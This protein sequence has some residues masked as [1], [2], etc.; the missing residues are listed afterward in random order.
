MNEAFAVLA[1]GGTVV[2]ANNRLAR[3]LALAWN[4]RE[5][6]AGRSAWHTPAV[7]S[8]Q[9]F[10]ES[11]YA[12]SLV[13]GGRAGGRTLLSGHQS[14]L[15]W[16]GLVAG[17]AGDFLPGAA[18]PVAEL[19]GQAWRLAQDWRI[20][21]AELQATADSE[22][23]RAFAGWAAAYQR[24][25]EV[26]GW[27]DAAAVCALLQVDLQAGSIDAPRRLHLAGFV[28]RTRLQDDLLRSLAVSGCVISEDSAQP[29]GALDACR[30][31]C[32][33]AQAEIAEAARW[34]RQLRA[35][36]AEAAIGIVVPE[37]SGRIA[38][39]RR[40]VLDVLAPDWRL[41]PDRPLPVNFSYGQPLARNGL[42]R[43]ALAVLEA[44]AGRID[45][46]LAAQLLASRYLPGYQPEA[47]GRARVDLAQRGRAGGSLSIAE[48]AEDCAAAAPQ[49]SERL[50]ALA[51][52]IARLPQRQPASSWAAAFRR[53]LEAVGWPGDQALASDEY[54]AATAWQELLGQMRGCDAILGPLD[55]TAAVAV[56]AGL[57][58]AQ[59]FQPA[60]D[61]AVIQVLGVMEAVG[62]RFDALWVCGMTSEAW[63]PAVRSN[64]L[65]SL[66]LQRERRLPD[67]TPALARERAERLLRWLETSADTVVFS[68]PEFEGD[69]PLAPSPLLAGL[70][71][72]PAGL[73]A[74]R[75][76][77]WIERMLGSTQLERLHPDPPPPVAP[78]RCVKGGV[79]LLEQEARCPA[80]AFVEFRLGAS[81]MPVPAA[82]LDAATRGNITHRI[83]ASFFSQVRSH[84][85][86]LALG[87]DE[88]RQQL[89]DAADKVLAG[90][91]RA[92]DP[93]LR[94]IA[95][96]ER[97]RQLDLV[98]SFLQLERQRAGF[99]VRETE[100]WLA[101]ANRSPSLARLQL[102][103][104]PDRIDEMPDGRLLVIDYKTGAKLPAAAEWL[105]PRPRSP[106]LP[107][108]ATLADA[109]A[110]AFVQL[111]AGN[112]GWCGLADE[113]WSDP[114][115]NTVSS[116][117]KGELTGWGALRE[118]W[119]LALEQ[120]AGEFLAGCF[121]LGRRPQDAPRGEWAMAIRPQDGGMQDEE[122]S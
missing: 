86:L 47:S 89:V 108:Y 66:Q 26:S 74:W 117:T 40:A 62:Q 19:A 67:S 54:Q 30:I 24:E 35:Q 80:R 92:A 71:A 97:E 122:L 106:Q 69:E 75:E 20:G 34:A 112:V 64:P 87:R 120:L 46:S 17:G 103:L 114:G 115:Y 52:E 101:D 98:G 94:R 15:L 50:A 104:R 55:R 31:R 77:L 16:Q 109:D 37:L 107:L 73:P 12:R 39:V 111:A 90:F 78:G 7:C 118:G 5:R 33:D 44:T 84:E 48:L 8:W 9:A 121:D 57:A 70:R 110:I 45:R 28:D 100:S 82:G 96:R 4:R 2:T 105:P 76:P 88:Q 6:D 91:Q 42:V 25:C 65:L 119:Q 18:R 59:L 95:A 49:I 58:Q 99:R 79:A 22:S 43:L 29:R 63:P 38:V 27:T 36:D 72:A 3:S 85:A 56:V 68:S 53:V 41:Q 60:G 81:E 32:K 1:E 113:D 13:Q 23:S 21:I 116:L 11:L 102:R 83:L 10:I 14:R 61:P 93:L 51:T